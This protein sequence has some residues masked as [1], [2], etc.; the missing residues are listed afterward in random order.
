MSF[1]RQSG[2]DALLQRPEQESFWTCLFRS[3]AKVLAKLLYDPFSRTDYVTVIREDQLTVRVVCISDTHNTEPQLPDGDILIHAGDLTQSGSRKEL[4][5][6]IDWLDNHP[7]QFKVVIAGNHDLYLDS[8]SSV[9]REARDAENKGSINWKSLIYLENSSTTL[10]TSKSQ[11]IKLFGSPYTPKHGN[12]A[13]QYP[14]ADSR[15]W[16]DIGIPDDTDILITHGPPRAHLDLGHLGCQHLLDK[17]WSMQRRPKLHVFGHIHGAYGKETVFWDSFQ[18]AYERI[19]RNEFNIL[20]LMTL[21]YFV[22]LRLVGLWSAEGKERTV[23]ANAASVGGVRDEKRRA[24]ICVD[25]PV[26]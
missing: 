4:E 23:M 8:L 10:N 1:S 14:R 15:S 7:H 21:L 6:Q 2:L 22:V 5:A 11:E 13:F 12:W 19:L 25:I 16:E 9:N 17:L 3:P 20:N 18:R 26:T 24:A